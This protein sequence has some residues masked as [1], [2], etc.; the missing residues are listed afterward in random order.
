M[1]I[2]V[3]GT[4]FVDIK[5]FPY[6][7]YL[8]TGRNA[9]SVEFIHGGVARNVVEDIA[10]LEL[11][12]SFIGLVDNNGTGEEVKRKLENHKVDTKYVRSVPDSMGMWLAV[13]DNSGDLAGSVSKR[14]DQKELERL[15]DEEGDE[16]FKNAD[17][18]VIE[19]DLGKEIIKRSI[20]L[21]EKYRK[22]IFA[23]VANMTLA[24]ERRDFMKSMDC[25]I[26]N[27]EEAGILFVEDFSDREPEEMENVLFDKITNA[28]IPSMVVTL[29]SR[30][31]VYAELGGSRGF[32]PA[33][34]VEVKDTTGAGDA[35]CAGVAAGLTY[36]R[37]LGEAVEIG[38]R[39]ASSVI[40]SSEN[41]CP[42]FLPKELGIDIEV[43]E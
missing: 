13:F 2:A 30:G 8:P 20:A 14:P 5:G 25:V 42:R 1:G 38:T 23:V 28:N 16:I 9:G 36:G 35:F 18:V 12:P 34:P 31:S 43:E 40:M 39:L 6:N 4:V 19:I 27:E 11:R 3:I 15:L 22:K 37:T 41:V 32:V 10:N 33:N 29:G 26:C 24:A 7:T 17:S 21:A